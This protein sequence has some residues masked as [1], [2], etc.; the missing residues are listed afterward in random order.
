MSG[1]PPGRSGQHVEILAGTEQQ[2][3]RREVL[4]KGG[5]DNA[6]AAQAQTALGLDPVEDV[7]AA[8]GIHD[9]AK[10]L[11]RVFE[12]EDESVVRPAFLARNPSLHL[13]ERRIEL[14]G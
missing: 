12:I 10:R 13:D 2:V 8:A 3:E 4:S 5:I 9:G 11:P 14:A 6:D 7:R 1:A